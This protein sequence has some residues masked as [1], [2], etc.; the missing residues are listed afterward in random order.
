MWLPRYSPEYNPE[1]FLNNDLKTSLK[2]H[3]LPKDTPSFSKT[4]RNI[5]D[6]IRSL[7]E[8]IQSYFQ[9]ANLELGMMS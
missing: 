5:L 7:P 3:P 1:E 6:E 2:N 8:R 9:L 4:I